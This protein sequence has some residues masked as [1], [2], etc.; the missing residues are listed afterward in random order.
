MKKLGSVLLA[1]FFVGILS[2]SA[3]TKYTIQADQAY[4]AQL[5]AQAAELYKKA[6]SKEK[7][8][9]IK[10]E[11]TW[12]MAEC[13]RMMGDWRKA[14]GY[15]T[16]A[17]KRRYPDPTAKLY[18]ADVLKAQGEYDE[19]I[20]AYEEYREVAPSDPRGREGVESCKK[21]L[22]WLET[23]SRYELEN[24]RDFNTK[25]NDF[26]PSWGDKDQTSIIFTSQRED[27]AGKD[28]DGWTDQGF[29]DLYESHEERKRG[30]RRSRSG[31]A[32][33]APTWSVPA[34]L[35]IEINT[36]AHEGFATVNERGNMLFFTRCENQKN[37]GFLGCR[38]YVSRKKGK[39]W[40]EPELVNVDVDSTSSI[41]HPF[42]IDDETMLIAADLGGEGGRDLY[43]LTYDRRGRSWGTPENLGSKINTVGFEGYP[44]VHKDGYL[45]FTSDGHPG[46]GAWDIFRAKMNS[47]GSFGEVENMLSPINSNSDDFALIFKGEEAANGYMTSN[48]EDGRGGDDIYRVRLKPLLYALQ[49]VVTDTKSGRAIDRVTVKLVGSD[50]AALETTTDETGAYAFGADQLAEGVNYTLNFEAKDYL[51]KSGSVTTVGIPLSA[52]EESGD[53]FL[54]TI[55]MNKDLDPIRKPIVLPK[56]E[57][58]FNSAELRPEAMESLDGLVEVL[59]DNPNITI[60]L[61]SHTDH[62]GSNPANQALS[63]RRA[64]S[65]VDYLISKGIA[66]DRLVAVGM[67][68]KEPFVIDETYTGPD[69]LENGNRLTEAFI[70]RLKRDNGDEADEVA[71]QLNR[72]TDFQVKS[73]NYVPKNQ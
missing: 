30:G 63:Q 25:E 54:H 22:E 26:A 41:G 68:E 13:Y 7:D 42:L 18:L 33:E 34:P 58:D 28:I 64:Q 37:S 51:T 27:G 69:Y 35:P 19:A 32:N 53:G 24:I 57:Y 8:R 62:I 9:Q 60:E 5:Y 10:E 17:I 23:P 11:I 52:F 50:G 49:G 40:G 45:Y 29:M 71:R 20:V 46:M 48:R 4:D 67:G 65:C 12:R 3:Q 44:F 1:L 59:E 55:E 70:N 56:I 15:Y 61:R 21:A 47:D 16:R 66:E 6:S 73:R 31:A 2:V 43:K 36:K 38:I 39:S 72:R 14:E